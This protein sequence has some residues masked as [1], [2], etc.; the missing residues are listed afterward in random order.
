MFDAKV[1]SN[2]TKVPEASLN[3][4]STTESMFVFVIASLLSNRTLSL[5]DIVGFKVEATFV[6]EFKGRKVTVGAVESGPTSSVPSAV[7][8]SKRLFPPVPPLTAVN[9]TLSLKLGLLSAALID[10]KSKVANPGSPLF[11]VTF[12]K[13][14]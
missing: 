13:K 8:L 12:A 4:T 9:S 7:K 5:N 6:A 10:E 1:A 2:G 11:G 3:L 14:V